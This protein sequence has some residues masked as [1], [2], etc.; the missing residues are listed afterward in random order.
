[1]KVKEN[2]A[3]RWL[4]AH[5]DYL[6]RV[7]LLRLGNDGQLAED[8][9]QET[10]LAA[11]RNAQNFEGRSSER[12]WLTSILKNKI[13]DYL[14]RKQKNLFEQTDFNQPEFVEDGP[15][16]GRWKE[17]MAPSDWGALPDA[18]FEQ[19]EFRTVLAKCLSGLPLNIATVF[20]LREVDGLDSK[21][22]CKEL[23]ITSSNLWVMLHRA[24]TGLRRCLELN[25][26]NK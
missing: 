12:T 9:V 13:I 22:V 16:K 11:L 17:S 2:P 7:A 25:W 1:M 4:E 26:M 8:M 23:G 6:Y 18:V 19:S 20:T 15:L 21:E 3:E 5:G 24:R 14:R 10:L